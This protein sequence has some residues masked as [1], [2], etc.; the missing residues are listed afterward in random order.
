MLFLIGSPA[1]LISPQISAVNLISVLVAGAF[2]V[3]MPQRKMRMIGWV[4]FFTFALYIACATIGVI[5]FFNEEN[6]R[7]LRGALVAA[8]AV[9]LGGSVH[10]PWKT[11]QISFILTSV[12]IVAMMVCALQVSFILTGLGLDPSLNN[13]FDITQSSEGLSFG[14]R[15]FFTNPN[16]L[17]VFAALCLIYFSLRKPH[18]FFR[19]ALCCVLIALG[20]SRMAMVI[21]L[22]IILI[23]STN[24]LRRM[25]ALVGVFVFLVVVWDG[26]VPPSG[27]YAVSRLNDLFDVLRSGVGVD[28]SLSL[29]LDS[30]LYFISQYHRFIIPSF[31]ASIPF[32]GFNHAS[33]D[34]WLVARSPHNF[35]VELHGLFGGLGLLIACGLGVVFFQRLANGFGVLLAMAIIFGVGLLS[36]VPSSLVNFHQFFFVAA[37]LCRASSWEC[38]KGPAMG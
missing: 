10:V 36:L 35:L 33:F 15:S 23:V 32:A 37:A 5:L 30:F 6:I 14:I 18:S 12:L 22:I 29:R 7:V 31:D 25:L 26:L 21:G 27:L 2:L 20:G 16:D 1:H 9:Y 28:G 13:Q 3:S 4:C 34:Y 24:S 17:S 38:K 11:E 8:V 19:V